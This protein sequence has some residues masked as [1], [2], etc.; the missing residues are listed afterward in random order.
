LRG[1]RRA[2]SRLKGVVWNPVGGGQILSHLDR[3]QTSPGRQSQLIGAV[4]SSL[5]V[6]RVRRT[7]T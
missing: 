6:V 5:G 4:M 3:Y 7:R 1:G 2:R